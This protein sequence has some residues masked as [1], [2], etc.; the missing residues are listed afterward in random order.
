[1]GQTRDAD[2]QPA[3]LYLV[4]PGGFD[5]QSFPRGLEA[6]LGTGLV[7][8]V[9]IGV[10]ASEETAE[11]EAALLVPIVQAHNAA[12]L[13]A[14]HTRA[15]GRARADGV[16]VSTGI[17][18]LKRAVERFTPK[19][20]VGAGSLRTRHA[21]MEAGEAGADYV[22]F[23]Q[24]HCDIRHEPHLRALDLAEWWS[25]LMEIPAVIMAGHAL[26]SVAVAGAT[27]A[28]FVA[29]HRAVWEHPG[30]PAEAV[31]VAHELLQAAAR[32]GEP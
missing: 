19:Q 3:L 1:M 23:G 32:K 16:H 24:P 18:D 10:G 27:G 31:L 30:G 21:A 26:E 12:A 17:G 22:F 20:I 25:D 15:A 28:G 9:L 8:A 29:L 14:E 4:T 2:E 11:Q 6:A 5:R 7:A 13:V